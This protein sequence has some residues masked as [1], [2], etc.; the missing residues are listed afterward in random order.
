MSVHSPYCTL[1]RVSLLPVYVLKSHK[2]YTKSPPFITDNNMAPTVMNVVLVYEFAVRTVCLAS[3]AM[4]GDI[5]PMLIAPLSPAGKV[6]SFCSYYRG[7]KLLDDVPLNELFLD[8]MMDPLLL[9]PVI[10]VYDIS[11]DTAAEACNILFNCLS[12]LYGRPVDGDGEVADDAIGSPSLPS[13]RL[14][15]VHPFIP[16]MSAYFQFLSLKTTF[17]MFD[18]PTHVVDVP[19]SPHTCIAHLKEL[20]FFDGYTGVFPPDSTIFWVST[21]GTRAYKREL[22]KYLRANTSYPNVMFRGLK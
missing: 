11:V 21:R 9:A 16:Q 15:I 20:G 17:H 14:R 12:D 22:N 5:L 13:L 10:Y 18:S 2:L 1:P 4:L 3:G 7:D 19:S 8:H 6:L